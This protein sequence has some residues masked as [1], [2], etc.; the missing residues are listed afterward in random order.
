[1]VF[2]ARGLVCY[3]IL[4]CAVVCSGVVLF[5]M[6]GIVHC[7]VVVWLECFVVVLC[8]SKCG[9]NNEGLKHQAFQN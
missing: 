4:C 5:T 6:C 2:A 8:R 9:E 7:S 1:M 3:V